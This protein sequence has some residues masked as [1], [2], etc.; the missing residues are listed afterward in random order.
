MAQRSGGFTKMLG[1]GQGDKKRSS[2]SVMGGQRLSVPSSA[3][4]REAPKMFC[5]GLKNTPPTH[6]AR[7]ESV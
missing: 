4:K 2:L 3:A 7:P 5:N 1:F 6:G